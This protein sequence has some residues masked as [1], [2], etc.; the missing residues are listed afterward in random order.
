MGPVFQEKQQL[1]PRSDERVALVPQQS[2][3][4]SK[5]VRLQESHGVCQIS[6]TSSHLPLSVYLSTC[7]PLSIDKRTYQCLCLLHHVQNTESSHNEQHCAV[8]SSHVKPAAPSNRPSWL[9]PG[10]RP[11]LGLNSG[12]SMQHWTLFINPLLK[13]LSSCGPLGSH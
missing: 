13:T 12:I 6:S 2:K 7:S 3:E 9:S 5:I 8:H 1:P 11:A 4:L 10:L